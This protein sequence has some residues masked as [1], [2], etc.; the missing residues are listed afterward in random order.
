ML[1]LMTGTSTIL[2]KAVG[3]LTP[4]DASSNK[5]Y[6]PFDPA[7]ELHHNYY[8][9]MSPVAAGGYF[10][11][12]FDSFRHYGNQGLQRQLWG[13]AIDVVPDGTYTTDKS[14]PAFYVTGQEPGTGNH[15]A[16]TALDPCHSDGDTC[17]TGVDCCGGFC[18]NGKCG[19]PK[20]PRCSNIDEACG[21]GHPECGGPPMGTCLC[22]DPRAQCIG[23]FCA[24]VVQ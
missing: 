15:R 9:T 23:G 11:I 4:Q 6:L 13:A 16:F 3:S 17:T 8:P 18:T 1:D 2:A 14:H 19:L 22:C 24:I 12:F 5:T 21:P 20:Q 10:W 7:E